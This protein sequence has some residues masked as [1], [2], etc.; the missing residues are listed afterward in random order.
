MMN[1]V[2]AK[3]WL[4]ANKPTLKDLAN[5]ILETKAGAGRSVVNTAIS[6]ELSL[7]LMWESLESQRQMLGD[8]HK[9]TKNSPL[10]VKLTARN[11]VREVL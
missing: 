9:V 4:I 8:N 11:V 2:E 1:K 5:L 7:A 10:R 6:K 3:K